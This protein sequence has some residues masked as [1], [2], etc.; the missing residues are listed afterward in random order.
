MYF[1]TEVARHPAFQILAKSTGSQAT[2]HPPRR[3]FD[4]QMNEGS[5]RLPFGKLGCE[6]ASGREQRPLDDALPAPRH[7]GKSMPMVPRFTSYQDYC[8]RLPPLPSTE[9][10]GP[11]Y[12]EALAPLHDNSS[13]MRPWRR[14][15]YSA[16]S[17]VPTTP[18]PDPGP[19]ALLPGIYVFSLFKKKESQ[20][21]TTCP[22]AMDMYC[23]ILQYRGFGA[24]EA[25]IAPAEQQEG[26]DHE[27][28]PN[29]TS[30]A[31]LAPSIDCEDCRCENQ[32]Q[33]EAQGG[34]ETAASTASRSDKAASSDPPSHKAASS[35]FQGDT[36][37]TAPRL[38]L[39]EGCVPAMR[40]E[41]P[42]TP[43]TERCYG[44][45]AT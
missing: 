7:F 43:V 34:V 21:K 1:G 39:T 36:L 19:A 9:A 15:A 25:T 8:R 12:R 30:T 33:P 6:E 41:H 11:R 14:M 20:D 18:R 31:S 24:N 28:K 45:R 5:H 3:P 35:D 4:S 16:A 27:G 17:L 22:N 26:H 40:D 44:G 29:S 32:Q 37:Q 23:N 13:Q 42:S 10:T 2:K 38:S